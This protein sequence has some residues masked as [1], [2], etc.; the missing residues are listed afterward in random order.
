MKIALLC[1]II[2]GTASAVIGQNLTLNS[3]EEALK[4]ALQHNPDLQLYQLKRKQAQLEHKSS[5]SHLLPTISGVITA[6]RNID[7]PVTPIP[8]EI[9]G[10]PGRTIEAQ[11]GQTYNYNVGLSLSKNLLDWQATLKSRVVKINMEMTEAQTAAFKQKLTE[12]VALYY[13]T[14]I[15]TKKALQIN[16]QDVQLAD[17]LFLLT[18]NKFRQGVTDQLAINQA[19]MHIHQLRQTSISNKILLNQCYQQLK[20][21]LG[22]DTQATITITQTEILSLPNNALPINMGQ[23]KSLTTYALQSKQNDLRVRME[24][25]AYLPKLSLTTYLGRQQFSNEATISFDR[26]TSNSYIGLNLSIPIFTGFSR[27]NQVKIAKVAQQEAKLT[28]QQ[29]QQKSALADATLLK[30]YQYTQELVQAS[31]DNF[32]L[33]KANAKLSFKRYQQGLINLEQYYR[34]FEDY[35]SAEQG[36]LSALSKLYG[37]QATIISRK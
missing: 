25:A 14:A 18:Q 7:L 32:R 21:L 4:Q 28:W 13:Y 1:L 6:Q 10:Q 3:V 2:C 30:E 8:G 5:R 20:T 23:D 24:R 11:F 9:F 16:A 22:A 27:S 15:I 31:Q 36:Y 17:S 37:Y 34:R 29:A 33:A 12:Q 19:R 26:W 35:L